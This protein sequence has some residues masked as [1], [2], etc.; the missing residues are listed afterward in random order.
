CRLFEF[1]RRYFDGLTFI[2]RLDFAD[3]LAL[4]GELVDVPLCLCRLW[5]LLRLACHAGKYR[6]QG[7]YV[8]QRPGRA[9]KPSMSRKGNRSRRA[10]GAPYIVALDTAPSYMTRK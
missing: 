9:G 1:P 10:S 7:K 4:R 2:N 5:R 3:P 6:P 8:Q